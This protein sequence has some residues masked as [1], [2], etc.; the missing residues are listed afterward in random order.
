MNEILQQ[1]NAADNYFNQRNYDRAYEQY[2]QLYYQL[3]NCLKEARGYR[4]VS[5]GVGFLAAILTGGFGVEDLLI[6]PLVNKALLSLFGIDVEQMLENF[7]YSVRQKLFCVSLS[8]SLAQRL[9]RKEVLINFV[10]GFGVSSN[11]GSLEDKLNALNRLVNPFVDEV[12][13]FESKEGMTEQQLTDEIL[14]Q[15]DRPGRANP[16]LTGLLTNYLC[17]ANL[18]DCILYRRLYALGYRSN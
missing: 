15:I 17:K 3:I 12:R 5:K 2:N 14:Y 18:T 9:S 11:Q 4:N 10:I 13:D 8:P 7:N 6:V 16:E 1:K